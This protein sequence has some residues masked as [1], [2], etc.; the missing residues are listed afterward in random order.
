MNLNN[1]LFMLL[2]TGIALQQILLWTYKSQF[3]NILVSKYIYYQLQVFFYRKSM[4]V[5]VKLVKIV[6]LLQRCQTEGQLR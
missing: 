6:Y 5:N 2:I 3:S 1:K 4:K